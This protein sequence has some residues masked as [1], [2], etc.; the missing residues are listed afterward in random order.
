MPC[1]PPQ[2]PAHK[3]IRSSSEGAWGFG[4]TLLTYMQL[5]DLVPYYRGHGE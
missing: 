2:P 1:A 5:L 4:D 3:L